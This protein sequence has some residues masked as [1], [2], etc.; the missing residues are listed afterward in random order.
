MFQIDKKARFDALVGLVDQ[1]AAW[2]EQWLEPF[3]HDIDDGFEQRMAGRDEFGLRL[4]C[5]Q[6]LLEGDPRIAVKHRI[7]AADQT[8]AL[9]ENR[10]ARGG[11]R[12]GPFPVRRYVRPAS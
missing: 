6:G 5:N 1:H 4:A 11:S 12:S 10:R 7:A 8:V 2:H 3:Q 9:L